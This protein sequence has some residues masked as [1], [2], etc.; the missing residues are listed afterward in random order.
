ML[1]HVLFISQ[2]RLYNKII[3]EKEEESSFYD[4]Y[5]TAFPTITVILE[6]IW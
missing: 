1:G 2:I 3:L 4:S 6:E 5:F